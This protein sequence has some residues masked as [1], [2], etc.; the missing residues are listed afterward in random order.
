M[1]EQGKWGEREQTVRTELLS[2]LPLC[3]I[4]AQFNGDLWGMLANTL[5]SC[6]TDGHEAGDSVCYPLIKGCLRTSSVEAEWVSM[7]LEKVLRQ[8]RR[9]IQW[10]LTW[11]VFSVPG[12]ALH[13]AGQSWPAE[14]G[15]W[16]LQHSSN[17]ISQ[18]S[19]ATI[20][21]WQCV[22]RTYNVVLAHS[23]YNPL[24]PRILWLIFFKVV[25]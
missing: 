19:S 3:A 4:F 13:H 8:K 11:W 18:W 24:Q 2:W 25:F 23:L 5:N 14:W 7:T 6:P 17:W 15:A 22:R 1:G 21:F 9:V 20:F 12:T 16:H 10:V